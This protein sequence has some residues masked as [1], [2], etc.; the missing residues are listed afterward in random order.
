MGGAPCA[1]PSEPVG[2]RGGAPLNAEM[3]SSGGL[4]EVIAGGGPFPMLV[5]VAAGAPMKP[6]NDPPADDQLTLSVLKTLKL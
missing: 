4:T 5:D 3:M 1:S 6:A 2:E